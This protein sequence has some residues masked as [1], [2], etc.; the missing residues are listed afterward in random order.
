MPNARVVKQGEVL[1]VTADAT[2]KENAKYL[3]GL[4]ASSETARALV[5]RAENIGISELLR[6][7]GQ[8]S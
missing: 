4:Y 6:E 5:D 7:Q 1:A 8:T 3:I 2:I